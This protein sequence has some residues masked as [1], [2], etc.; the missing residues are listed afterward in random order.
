MFILYGLN[1]IGIKNI[2]FI[3]YQ[4]GYQYVFNLYNQIHIVKNNS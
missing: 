1:I 3:G 2:I 4:L